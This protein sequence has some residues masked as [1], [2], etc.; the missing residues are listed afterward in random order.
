MRTKCMCML[1]VHACKMSVMNAGSACVQD[2]R[3]KMIKKQALPVD[4]F[5]TS[6]F[7]WMVCYSPFNA[8]FVE[9][10]GSPKKIDT[11]INI[12]ESIEGQKRSMQTYIVS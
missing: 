8:L 11:L 9:R 4:K 2:E 6:F 3:V 7:K 10:K 12:T 1:E 5:S